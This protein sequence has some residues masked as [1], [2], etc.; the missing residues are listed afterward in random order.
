MLAAIK[1]SMHP[2]QRFLHHVLGLRDAA[3]HPVG[4]TPFVLR[5][6]PAYVG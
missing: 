3:E 5:F 1:R 4:K 6:R 2:Q